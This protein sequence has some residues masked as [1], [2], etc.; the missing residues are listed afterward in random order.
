MNKLHTRFE[1]MPKPRQ[2]PIRRPLLEQQ[3]VTAA[4]VGSAEHKTERWWGGFPKAYV[5]ADGAAHR[6]GKQLTTICPKVNE[7][8]RDTA[9]GWVRQALRQGQLRYYE[10]D[11]D[12]P[13]HIWYRDDEG[14]PWFGFCVNSVQG[15]Y[16]GWPAEEYELAIFN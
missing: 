15:H 7:Q 2:S 11:K 8:E 5:G 12:F 6:P 4:Y 14:Q 9:T 10:G 13:K 1:A 3:I 16:K